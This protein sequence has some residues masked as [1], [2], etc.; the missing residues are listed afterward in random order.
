MKANRLFCYFSGRAIANWKGFRIVHV[1]LTSGCCSP[2]KDTEKQLGFRTGSRGGSHL[3]MS[4]RVEFVR[5]LS[6]ILRAKIQRR[7]SQSDGG[8]Y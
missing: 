6:Q 8:A 3:N 2:G 5:Q 7:G 4:C 1:V